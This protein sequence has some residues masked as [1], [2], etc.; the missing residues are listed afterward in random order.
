MTTF[1]CA[2]WDRRDWFQQLFG[3]KEADYDET[4]KMLKVE[5]DA[6]KPGMLV[7]KSLANGTFFRIGRFE[8]PSL[9]ELRSKVLEDEPKALVQRRLKVTNEIGDVALKHALPENRLATFQVASQFN[10]LEFVGPSVVP[11][12]GITGYV[13]DRTQGPACSIACGP[14]TAFR[15][16]FVPMPSGQEGQRKGMQINNLEDFSAELQRLCQPEPSGPEGRP[17]GRLGAAPSFRVTSG[18]TQASHREL[19]KLN[20]SLS[21]LSNED[22]EALRDTLRIGLHEEVQVTATAWGAKRLATEEQLV[23]QVFGS[24]CS[25]AYNRDSSSEDWQPLAT[26]ILEA[27]YEATLLAALKQ[28]KKHA[29]QE[30]SKKVFLTCLGGGVF[31]NSMEWIV[32]AMDRAFQRLQDADLDVRIVTY[33]G[34]PG[35]ELR[36]LER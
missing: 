10:C 12:D 7:L 30:G 13:M 27:S 22:L 8:T 18:Y 2:M 4:K 36:C 32:Q 1:G 24:A 31:G 19:Q 28:A 3:F 11:E 17:E 14:A 23:T 20:R 21:R 35:P 33:A 34:S 29:G 25:V 6:D 26:L 16:F 5:N 9:K 15:N